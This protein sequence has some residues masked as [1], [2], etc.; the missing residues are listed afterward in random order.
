MNVAL[1]IVAG[2]LAAV[3]LISTSKAFVPRDKIV[4]VGRHRCGMD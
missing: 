1:W 3:L 2:L 4:A